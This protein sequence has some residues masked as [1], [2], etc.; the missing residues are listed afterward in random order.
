M[1]SSD[2]HLLI[3]W[4]E[5][6]VQPEGIRWSEEQQAAVHADALLRLAASGASVVFL[7]QPQAVGPSAGSRAVLWSDI[8]SPDGGRPSA[9]AS[10]FALIGS[11]LHGDVVTRQVDVSGDVSALATADWLLLVNRRATARPVRVNGV[12]Y[13]L[14]AYEVR[15]IPVKG[16]LVRLT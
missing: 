2:L 16:R 8:R 6:Y 11:V 10:A 14:R 7:W 9:T 5:Y 4:S 13:D 3:W 15:A 1:C 12:S